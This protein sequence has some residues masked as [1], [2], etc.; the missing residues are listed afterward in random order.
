VLDAETSPFIDITA[1]KM[2]VQLAAAL[3]K[4]GTELRIAKDI[5]QFQDVIRN[6]VPEAFNN[7][8]FPTIDEAL[9]NPTEK[10]HQ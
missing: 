4:E 2:L 10:T 7:K 9:E 8:V 3:R 6:A 5:G 1:A